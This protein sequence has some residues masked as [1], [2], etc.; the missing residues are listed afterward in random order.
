MQT[1]YLIKYMM[2]SKPLKYLLNTRV[3]KSFGHSLAINLCGMH[4]GSV[5][6]FKTVE[7]SQIPY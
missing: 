5:E 4:F 6:Y 2:S 3:R 1:S 7:K